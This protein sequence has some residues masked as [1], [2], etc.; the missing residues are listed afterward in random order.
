VFSNS[1]DAS[2]D[3]LAGLLDA[4]ERIVHDANTWR[5]VNDGVIGSDDARR[6]VWLEKPIDR[7]HEL[8]NRMGP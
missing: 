3:R 2:G 4:R 8:R 7:A 1:F 5:G 6:W